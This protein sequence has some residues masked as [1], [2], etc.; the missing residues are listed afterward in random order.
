ME[1]TCVARCTIG[2]TQPR[3]VM[4]WNGTYPILYLLSGNVMAEH[5]IVYRGK[6][7]KQEETRALTNFV[8]VT[9]N[10]PCASVNTVTL[11]NT[12][13]LIVKLDASIKSVYG[14]IC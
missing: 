11:K 4:D 2:A 1:L 14:R 12:A 5:R 8:S 13:V 7:K 10:S 9:V 6:T 3:L